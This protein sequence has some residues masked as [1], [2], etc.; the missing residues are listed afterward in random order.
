MR[1]ETRE[2][3]VATDETLIPLSAERGITVET[4]QDAGIGIVT[5]GDQ[6]GWWKIPYPHRTGV[7][8]TRYRNPNPEGRPKYLDDPG[9]TFHIYNP[10]KLGPGEPEVWFAEGEFD[11]LCLIEHGV[12]AMGIH[13]VSN[14]P[15]GERWSDTSGFRRSWA[16]LFEDTKCVTMFDNDEAG[17]GAG[18][19]LAAA[20]GGVA[21]D[22]W[23]DQ[24]SDINEWHRADGGSLGATLA[25]FRDRIHNSGR[26]VP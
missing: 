2:P 13:G 16:L 17:R 1:L 18:R 6:Q 4:L 19:R 21:F 8:K 3:V 7:W 24:Y 26:M 10:L 11:T 22:D 23:D 5:E 15:D 25:R 20:L 14:V 9:A 12:P